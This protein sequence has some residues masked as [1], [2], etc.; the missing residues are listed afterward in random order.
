MPSL[1]AIGEK[2]H[3]SDSVVGAT[4]MAVGGGAPSLVAVIIGV[5]IGGNHNVAIGNVVGELSID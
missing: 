2:L 5:F 3:M 1:L 4:F